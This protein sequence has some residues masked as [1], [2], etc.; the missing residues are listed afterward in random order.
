MRARRHHPRF[1]APLPVPPSA[2]PFC[3][4]PEREDPANDAL[5]RIEE[6]VRQVLAAGGEFALRQR[7][8]RLLPSVG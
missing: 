3:E 5:D 8:A 7:L 1:S 4:A 6:G 2:R